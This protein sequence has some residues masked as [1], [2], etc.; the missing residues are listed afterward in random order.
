MNANTR[1]QYQPP[2]V[3]EYGPIGDHTFTNPGGHHKTCGTQC[4]IDKFGEL[5]GHH[6]NFGDSKGPHSS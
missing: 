3:V 2:R 6:D 1:Q 5:T 4:H